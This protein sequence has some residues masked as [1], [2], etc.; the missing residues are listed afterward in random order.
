MKFIYIL[1]KENDLKLK[2]EEEFK[3]DKQIKIKK[4]LPNQFEN[5]LKNIPDML[6]INE[7]SLD[8]NLIDYCKRVRNDEENS[9]TPI[10]VV[11]SN[12]DEKHIVE[13]LKNEVEVYL[14]QPVNKKI[15]YY[16]T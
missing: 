7:D 16:K 11:S 3:S 8:G 6:V 2:L 5:I 4:F 15:L 9:I 12:K 10:V 1:D 14:E 13:V